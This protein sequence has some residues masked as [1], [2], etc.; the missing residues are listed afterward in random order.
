[1]KR[2]NGEILRDLRLKNGLTMEELGKKLK[3]SASFINSMEKGRKPIPEELLNSIILILGA[4]NKDKKEFKDNLIKK[5]VPVF[6]NNNFTDK[7]ENGTVVTLPVYGFAS[8]GNGAINFEEF[9]EEEFILPSDMKV[10]KNL[11]VIK[12]HGDSMEPMF[13]NS[14]RVLLEPCYTPQTYE[15]WKAFNHQ[16]VVVR[17]F[18]ERFL[19]EIVFKK[20]MMYL[21]SFNEDLYPEIEVE[22]GDDIYC[23][24]I[25][26]QLIKRDVRKI[27]YRRF[28]GL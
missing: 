14:D 25:V 5:E 3:R 24:G 21:Y 10:R 26:T 17:Y 19:K 27:R 11:K 12:I 7:E 9:E 23:E 28:T 20:G 6:L 15:E 2:T 1:M 22:L 18:E 16:I 13:F 4:T 8:A